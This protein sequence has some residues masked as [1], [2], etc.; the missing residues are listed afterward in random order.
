MTSGVSVS[1][2]SI[3]RFQD[4]KS[5]K[6]TRYTIFH[7]SDDETEVVPGETVLKPEKLDLSIEAVKT[8][9]KEFC[10]KLS[11]TGCCYAVYDLNYQKPG[12]ARRDKI[13]LVS[14]CP[15]NSPIRTKMIYTSTFGT[16]KGA[17]NGIQI[18][19]QACDLDDLSFEDIQLRVDKSS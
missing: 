17:L 5:G 10:A 13:L 12:G 8:E 18:E 11:P 1:P 9:W 14:W 7:L 2:E 19:V 15:S 16:F 4:I 3:N 6:K